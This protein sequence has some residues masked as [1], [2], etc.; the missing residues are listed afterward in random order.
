MGKS[1]AR[2]AN[3]GV[4][5]RSLFL[6]PTVL[7]A[8][9]LLILIFVFRP[10]VCTTSFQLFERKLPRKN[11]R[12][13]FFGKYRPPNE[14]PTFGI[15]LAYEWRRFFEIEF[16]T[17]ALQELPLSNSAAKIYKLIIFSEKTTYHVS[18]NNQN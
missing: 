1:L 14:L 9:H 15:G 13:I 4:V 16:N 11:L 8:W 12:C 2:S 5:Q 3:C 6:P 17:E 10:I 7:E 18:T